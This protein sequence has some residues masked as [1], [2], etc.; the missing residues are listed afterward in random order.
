MKYLVTGAGGQLGCEWVETLRQ[1]DMTFVSFDSTA[2]DIT[3]HDRVRNVLKSEKPE[4]VINCAAYT[5]VEGAEDQPEKA[6]N[7]NRDAVRTLAVECKNTDTLFVHFSTDYVFPGKPEDMKQFPDGYPEEAETGP[8]NIYGK[9]KLEGEAAI[10]E[11]GVSHLILRVS[12]LCGKY[13]SNFVKTMLRLAEESDSLKV[14]NDQF[15]SPTYVDSL[16]SATLLLIDSEKTGTYHFTSRGLISWYDYASAIFKMSNK[17]ISIQQVQTSE[18]QLKAKRPV[19][20]KLSTRKIESL[21]PKLTCG[22]RTGLQNL[23]NRL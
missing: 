15:G 9:S 22:W 17:E 2:L 20:S 14:V 6:F 21:N 3:D 10:R 19:F 1:R 7:I 18:F 23:L 4:V 12:W 16:I 8:Q 13:G 11:S 5:D